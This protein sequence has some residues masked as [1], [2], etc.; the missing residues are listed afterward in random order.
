MIRQLFEKLKRENLKLASLESLTGG[1][2]SASITSVPGASEVFAGSA[3]TYVDEAKVNLGVDKKTIDD[4]GAISSEC[5]KEMARAAIKTYQV[6]VA[7]SFTGNAG[8]TSIEGKPV[9]LV[10]ISFII[11]DKSFNYKL[12]LDGDRSMIREQCVNFAIKTLYTKLF[13]L[14]PETNEEIKEDLSDLSEEPEEKLSEVL[15]N[16]EEEERVSE[17]IEEESSSFDET[18]T[19]EIIKDDGTVIDL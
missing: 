8:P 17:N 9:G 19:E 4:H 1:L 18:V 13:D 14:Y 12:N 10:Y 6:D 3:V 2:F 15:R 16:L 7:V 11:K 5:A